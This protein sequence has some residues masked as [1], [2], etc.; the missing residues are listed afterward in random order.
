MFY[1]SSN[2]AF[3]KLTDILIA[4]LGTHIVFPSSS[5]RLLKILLLS[6]CV[7]WFL[8]EDHV[9]RSYFLCIYIYLHIHSSYRFFMLFEN[10]VYGTSSEKNISHYHFI[11]CSNPFL[12]LFIETDHPTN[13]LTI[14]EGKEALVQV[15][16]T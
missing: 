6:F 5:L 3:E 15:G 8:Y 1:C 9:V 13:Y 14:S 12:D 10:Y 2:I 7:L 11:T 4:H 16:E